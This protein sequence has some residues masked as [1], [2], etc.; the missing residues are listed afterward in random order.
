MARGQTGLSPDHP[1]VGF[2]G[3]IFHR[4]AQLMAQSFDLLADHIP[5][6]NLLIIGY[7]PLDIKDLVHH[8]QQVIQTGY[9]DRK[10]INTYLAACDLFWLP[11]NDSLANRGRFPLKLTDYMACGRPT[12]ATRVGDVADIIQKYSIGLVCEPDAS[13]FACATIHLLTSRELRIEQGDRARNT[14]INQF[15]W[16]TMAEKLEQHYHT[17]LRSS[18]NEKSLSE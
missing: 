8:P 16:S 5:D 6:V 14:A 3:T 4:D 10:S 15:S 18:L 7:C 12:V 2:I 1:V 13:E 9:I 11:L 17:I